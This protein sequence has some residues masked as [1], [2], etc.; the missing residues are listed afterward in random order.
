MVQGWFL[1]P[2]NCLHPAARPRMPWFASASP[3]AKALP[4]HAGVAKS[5]SRDATRPAAFLYEIHE[6]ARGLA[7]GEFD[8]VHSAVDN[9]V[10]MVEAAKEGRVIVTGRRQRHERVLRPGVRPFVRRSSR[11]Q[12]VVDAPKHGVRDPGKK[13]LLK[14]ALKDGADYTVVPVDAASC[15]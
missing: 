14:H 5:I 12:L 1:G 15:A 4:L 8:I 6:A 10:A 13:I 7:A 9:A 11:T 3:N 2:G